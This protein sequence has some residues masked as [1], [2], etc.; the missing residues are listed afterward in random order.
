[1]RPL[2]SARE[3]V[4]TLAVDDLSRQSADGYTAGDIWVTIGAV[5]RLRNAWPTPDLDQP[6]ARGQWTQL[7]QRTG[8]KR[9]AFTRE[10]K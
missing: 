5:F 1:M 7:Y 8:Q 4:A 9:T 10:S 3:F 2:R 6:H